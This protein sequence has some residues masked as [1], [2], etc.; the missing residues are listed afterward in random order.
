MDLDVNEIDTRYLSELD[1]LIGAQVTL[2]NKD[3]LPLLAIVKKWNLIFKGKPV[4][5]PNLSPILASRIYELE[6]PDGRIREYSVNVI[7]E[8]MV[9]Q[10]KSNDWTQVFLI[11]SFLQ[12]KIR[13]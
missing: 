7:L 2:P 1:S 9:D 8:N 5:S 6:F 12:E 11:R 10:V 13:K 4:G 3:G